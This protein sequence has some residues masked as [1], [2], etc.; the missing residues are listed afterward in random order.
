M[1]RRL[2]VSELLAR[3]FSGKWALQIHSHHALLQHAS[4]TRLCVN[5]FGLRPALVRLLD[6]CLMQPCFNMLLK[7]GWRDQQLMCDKA[8]KAGCSLFGFHWSCKRCSGVASN[9]VVQWSL[10]SLT[11][12]H[13]A[14]RADTVSCTFGRTW[15]TWLFFI[16]HEMCHSCNEQLCLITNVGNQHSCSVTNGLSVPLEQIKTMNQ[17]L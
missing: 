13:S 3:C 11:V 17:F 6:A 16:A 5:K 2:Y 4:E 10:H 8:D 9:N 14:C 1:H 7:L 15:V 12:S